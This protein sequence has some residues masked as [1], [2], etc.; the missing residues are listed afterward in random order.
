M[1][2]CIYYHDGWESEKGV[3]CTNIVIAG[4]KLH[5]GFELCI[6]SLFIAGSV[7]F[8]Q[9]RSHGICLSGTTVIVITLLDVI[10]VGYVR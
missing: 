9:V 2:T 4:S 6:Q 10:V 5:Y 1:I 8:C 7:F 3:Q